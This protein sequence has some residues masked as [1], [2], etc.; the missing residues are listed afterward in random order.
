[1]KISITGERARLIDKEIIT[2]GSVGYQLE[3]EFDAEWDGLSKTAVFQSGDTAVSVILNPSATSVIV[4]WEVLQTPNLELLVGIYGF[5]LA[6][7]ETVTKATPTIYCKVG[8]IQVG[9]DPNDADPPMPSP[10]GTLIEQLQQ[11]V[12]RLDEEKAD[13]TYVDAHIDDTDVHTT[14]EEKESWDTKN[15]MPD[16]AKERI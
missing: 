13:K 12:E 7:D 5:T 8:K 4:P 6:D 14:V 16:R 15:K 2:S 10:T 9:T 1:M 11:E 3:L